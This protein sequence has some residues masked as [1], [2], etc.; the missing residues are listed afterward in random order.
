[1]KLHWIRW[2]VLCNLLAISSPAAPNLIALKH[3][4]ESLCSLANAPEEII[5]EIIEPDEPSSVCVGQQFSIGLEAN[6]STGYAWQLDQPLDVSLIQFITNLYIQPASELLGAPGR[7]LWVFKA[8]G[9]GQARIVLKYVRPWQKD[10]APAKLN[11]FRLIVKE[12]PGDSSHCKLESASA[13]Q[14]LIK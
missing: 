9:Q 6:P 13:A 11:T 10:S 3:S 4:A 14:H 5:K 12:A 2:A 8:I 1:M 7:E